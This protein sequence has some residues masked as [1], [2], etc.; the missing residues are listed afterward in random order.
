MS[1][2]EGSK[3][4]AAFPVETVGGAT[5]AL[6]IDLG[7]YSLEAVLRAG[8]KLTD[9]CYLLFTRSTVPDRL[10]AFLQAKRDGEDV[11]V[12]VRELAN[13]LLDQQLRRMIAEEVGP[14]R[15]LI[16]AQAFAEGNLLDRDRDDGDYESDPRGIGRRR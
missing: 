4:S 12:L 15:E 13:E 16:V 10:R 14:V 8:Y 3:E 2:I 7:V 9:R 5:V 6:E 11:E 1:G